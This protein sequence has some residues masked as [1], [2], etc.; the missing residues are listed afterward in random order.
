M[1]PL[2]PTTPAAGAGLSTVASVPPPKH[3]SGQASAGKSSALVPSGTKVC[4]DVH[5]TVSADHAGLAAID[6]SRVSETDSKRIQKL[7]F[8]R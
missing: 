2:V 6:A 8:Y 5:M 1:T 7:K 3:V 4:S